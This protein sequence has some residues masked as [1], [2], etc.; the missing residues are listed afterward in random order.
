MQRLVR[1]EVGGPPWAD[2]R[3]WALRS[4]IDWAA[5]IADSGVPLQIWWSRNDR[6][7]VDQAAQSGALNRA[8]RRLHPDAPVV[9]IVGT[10]AHSAEFKA[11]RRLPFA[12]ALF[13][14]MPPYGAHARGLVRLQPGR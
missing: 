4:P 10:W 9:E 14:L 7:V 5:A 13:G 1:A 3:A 2:P 6:V 8:I 11:T 12:L